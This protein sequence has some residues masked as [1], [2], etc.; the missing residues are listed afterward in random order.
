MNIGVYR[1]FTN[2]YLLYCKMKKK[3]K[4]SGFAIFQNGNFEIVIILVGPFLFNLEILKVL[5]KF[6]HSYMVDLFFLLLGKN[7]VMN[8]GVTRITFI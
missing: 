3:K 2:S 8:I 6:G 7:N 4:K 5:W 1:V